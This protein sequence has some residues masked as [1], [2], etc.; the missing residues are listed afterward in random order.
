VNVKNVSAGMMFCS[1]QAGVICSM[2][3]TG[4]DH[5][6]QSGSR[7]LWIIWFVLRRELWIS[8]KGRGVHNILLLWCAT[9]QSFLSMCP[10]C[11]S[12]RSS[13][14]SKRWCCRL[15]TVQLK[16]VNCLTQSSGRQISLI[17]GS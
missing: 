6:G 15:C 14:S 10:R 4:H 13:M 8:F 5:S 2:C 17:C 7:I 9:S 3:L 1:G 16:P 11:L 12:V